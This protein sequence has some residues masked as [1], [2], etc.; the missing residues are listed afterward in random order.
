MLSYH[1]GIS[2]P[3]PFQS[4][5]WQW[6]FN[7]RP[8]WAYSNHELIGSGMTAAISFFM[9]PIICWA[10]TISV[11]TLLL[12]SIVKPARTEVFII[13]GYLTSLVPWM[14]I[15]RTKYAYH[16]FACVP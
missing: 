15:S 16:Y 10:G 5:W 6:L 13:S 1:N 2:Q 4:E 7:L 3:H 8:L 9:N 12:I 14:I 11:A